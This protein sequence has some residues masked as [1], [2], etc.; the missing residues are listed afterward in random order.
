MG[1]LNAGLNAPII[2]APILLPP[3]WTIDNLGRTTTLRNHLN[4]AAFHCDTQKRPS[5]WPGFFD[6]FR[7][8]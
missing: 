5:A 8:E 7:L 1:A 3:G 2:V 4:F 6:V